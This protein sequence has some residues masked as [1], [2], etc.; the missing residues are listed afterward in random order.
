VQVGFQV[1]CILVLLVMGIRYMRHKQDPG[2]ETKFL[3]LEETQ[4]AKAQ[5]LGYSSPFFLGVLI[6]VANL[7]SP[8][9]IPSM[10]S[11]VSYIQANGLLDH[12]AGD[13][14]AYAFGFGIGTATWFGMV[15]RILVRYRTKF[16]TAV[17][18]NIYKFAGGTF[19]LCGFLLAYHVIMST[20]WSKWG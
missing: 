19:L 10:I 6:A 8:M 4:E 9:F 2:E 16:S 18:S 15:A 3:K 5:R 1:A 12:N 7:A 11:V 20:D 14:V 17:L 13:N